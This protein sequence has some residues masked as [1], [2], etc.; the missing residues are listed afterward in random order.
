MY[1]IS[2]SLISYFQEAEINTI[3]NSYISMKMLL[4][5]Y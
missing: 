4:L 1:V 3:D 5:I 2:G